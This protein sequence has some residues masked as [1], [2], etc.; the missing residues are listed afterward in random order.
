MIEASEHAESMLYPYQ[1]MPEQDAQKA[2][3]HPTVIV[4]GG[5]VAMAHEPFVLLGARLKLQTDWTA[6][7]ACLT[8]ALSGM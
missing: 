2:T 8:R 1:R 7:S 6:E 3:R 5:P 4:G